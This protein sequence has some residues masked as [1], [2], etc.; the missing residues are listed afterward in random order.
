M[1]TVTLTVTVTCPDEVDAGHVLSDYI[2]AGIEQ[3]RARRADDNNDAEASAAES[4]IW[5]P[6]M[7][8]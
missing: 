1:K 5:G 3:T 4:C 6:V 7:I 8:S 2:E